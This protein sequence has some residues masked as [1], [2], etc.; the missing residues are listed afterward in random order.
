MTTTCTTLK[1]VVHPSVCL[2]VLTSEYTNDITHVNA[3]FATFFS[4]HSFIRALFF[5]FLST[6]LV[7]HP[8]AYSVREHLTGR[9]LVDPITRDVIYH[10]TPTHA[11]DAFIHSFIFN[12]TFPTRSST[13]III[14]DDVFVDAGCDRRART[15]IDGHLHVDVDEADDRGGPVRGRR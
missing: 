2:F 15:P 5:P 12:G 3:T 7:G 1:F 11:V 8:H 14:N 13:R 9:L 4:M 10:T 6:R